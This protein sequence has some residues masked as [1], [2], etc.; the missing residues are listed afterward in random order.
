MN[1]EPSPQR[2]VPKT[3]SMR[4]DD[5]EYVE[6]NNLSC[7]DLIRFGIHLHRF[8]QISR[9]LIIPFSLFLLAWILAVTNYFLI[10]DFIQLL[11]SIAIASAIAVSVLFVVLTVSAYRR[12]MQHG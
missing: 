2:N 6:K 3:V 4:P 5:L 7:T 12:M 1:G 10:D 11:T 9:L 8:K